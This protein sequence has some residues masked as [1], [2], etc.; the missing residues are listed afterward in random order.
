MNKK[1]FAVMFSWIFAMIAGVIILLSLVYFSVQHTDL[2]GRVSA[3]VA[4]EEL[5]IT[6]G[7]LKS[8][9][10]G[11]TLE[12]GK[13]IK[14]EFKCN[15]DTLEKEK[16]YINKKAG[17]SLKGKVVF[18]PSELKS[19]SFSLFTLDWNV[20]FKVTNFIF[21]TDKK[22]NF[23]G[24]IPLGLLEKIPSNIDIIDPYGEEISF[25]ESENGNCMDNSGKKIFYKKQDTLGE[26]YGKICFDET[27][28]T[29]VGDAMIF[30]AIFS[31]ENNFKCLK[32]YAEIKARD[33][34]EI[35]AKKIENFA[36]SPH[37]CAVMG[38]NS[39]W[40]REVDF[41][42]MESVKEI[43]QTNDRLVRIGECELIF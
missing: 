32:D 10:I 35:Y 28:Y 5:D 38:I 13:P 26:Y 24:V 40:V 30:A 14:L 37:S 19:N 22:Y 9:L 42:V 31:D 6:F 29:F 21:L 41:N 39:E 1:G 16:L 23:E 4:V 8:S 27:V 2:F 3:Q 15:E 34:A 33:V 36:S 20:P 18:A 12:L 7:S 11:T 43:K 25:E 17:K